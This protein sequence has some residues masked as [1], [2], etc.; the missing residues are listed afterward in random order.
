M[1]NGLKLY[2]VYVRSA[3]PICLCDAVFL[4]SAF[5]TNL[6]KT[7]MAC[8]K[9]LASIRMWI[10]SK[11]CAL[12]LPLGHQLSYPVKAALSKA[13]AYDFNQ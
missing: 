10:I 5:T 2:L 4:H 13:K 7:A 3:R 11:V 12:L 8:D 9:G 1:K 6:G